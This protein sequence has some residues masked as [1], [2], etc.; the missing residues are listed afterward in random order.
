M[1]LQDHWNAVY[2]TK[3]ERDVSWF[4]ASPSVSLEMLNAAGLAEDTCLIDI[5]GGDSRL[6]DALVAKGLD[7]LAVLDVS[8]VALRR[9]QERLGPA[10]AALVWIEADV[11]ADWHSKPVD[12]W[13]DRAVFHFLTDAADRARYRTHLRETL[14]PGGSAV[15]ATFAAHGPQTC[16]GL[17]VAR[18]GPSE[19]AAEFRD[20]LELVETRAHD[21]RTPWGAIQPFLYA[22]FTRRPDPWR[23]EKR[24]TR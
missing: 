1:S 22:R 21:H 11:T 8:G 4:E 10:A 16:S 20:D 9:A 3:G 6:V 18:Y 13:H 23:M 7:C 12:I 15:I 17:P 24:A 5:G 14:K 2:G 19:L